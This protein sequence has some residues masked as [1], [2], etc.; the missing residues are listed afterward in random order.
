M[1]LF[2]I[3]FYLLTVLNCFG[4]FSV[5]GKII[6]FESKD[7]SPA[8]MT[9]YDSTTNKIIKELTIND[10]GQ[11]HCDSLIGGTYRIEFS[12]LGYDKVIINNLKIDSDIDLCNLFLYKSGY[13][14]DGVVYKKVFFGLFRKEV[15][16]TGGYNNG[17]LGTHTKDK[18]ILL[19]YFCDQVVDGYYIDKVLTIDYKG[20]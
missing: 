7:P 3:T 9:I 12:F 15:K 6:D 13:I 17:Y 16:G 5:R 4:Q 19:N 1:R 2:V 20:K 11:F 18:K 10:S 8:T 14:W